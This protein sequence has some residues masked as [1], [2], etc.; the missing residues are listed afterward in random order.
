[1]LTDIEVSVYQCSSSNR[2]YPECTPD[3]PPTKV[4]RFLAGSE[5]SI[6]VPLLRSW[7]FI[8]V[9]N[10]GSLDAKV[11]DVETKYHITPLGTLMPPA[12]QSK[13]WLF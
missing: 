5:G 3:R 7:C 13:G 1:M 9:K 11:V 12:P 2:I 6:E 8:G 4:H 10:V